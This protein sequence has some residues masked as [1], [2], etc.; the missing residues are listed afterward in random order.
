MFYCCCG[1]AGWRQSAK[2]KKSQKESGPNYRDLVQLLE[3]FKQEYSVLQ[4]QLKDD[5][6]AQKREQDQADGQSKREEGLLDERIA[7][8]QELKDFVRENQ[9]CLREYL[10]IK[11]GDSGME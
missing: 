2:E 5:S 4:E 1:G 3:D 8:L 11:D 10:G 6:E 7:A 9:D